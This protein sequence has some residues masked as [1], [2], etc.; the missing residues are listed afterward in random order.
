MDLYN[1]YECALLIDVLM[2]IGATS[3]C[4]GNSDGCFLT[5]ANIRNGILKDHSSK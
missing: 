1:L 3:L 5:L 2:V 4:E